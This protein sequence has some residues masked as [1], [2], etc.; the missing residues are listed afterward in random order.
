VAE[1]RSPGRFAEPSR[2]K[3]KPVWIAIASCLLTLGAVF[4]ALNAASGEKKIEHQLQRLYGAEDPQFRRT[5]GVLLGPPIV[6][7]NRVEALLNGDAIFAAML[8]AI[9]Q[10][11]HSITFETYIYWSETIGREFA[12]ALVARSR[13]GVRVHVL[14]DWVGSAKMEQRYLD[15]MKHAGV[16]VERY[17]KPNWAGLFRMN[18]RT[19]RKV[20]VVDGA[21]GFTGG[22]GIADK[23]RGNAQDSEH[24]RDTHFRVEGPVVA[25]MQSVFMDNWIKATGR[26]LH[27]ERYFPALE[28]HGEQ[29]AQMFSSSPTGGS[30]SMHLMYLMALTAATRSIQLSSSYFVPDELAV[31]ALVAAA[32]RG[33]KVQIIT[34]GGEIDSDVVRR[35]SRARWGPLLEA[36]VLIAEYQPTMFHC[37]VL[38][39]DG[40]LVSVGSTNFDNRSFRLNDEANLNVVSAPFA[41]QQIEVFQRDLQQSKPITLQAWQQRPW[42]EKV[43]ERAASW[44]GSQL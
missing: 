31:K 42:Q 12:D 21:V 7:G 34:P 10:A 26:V 25:Q 9:G 3:T 2:M 17:H 4:V 22:V 8:Q 41:R 27:G 29:A 36:G 14:L 13:A 11:R 40:L 5:L 28:S 32:R 18:N 24:W 44:F 38:V 1:R 37:K 43:L 16:E 39:V 23:W 19:H 35:A 20:L 30:E 15:E 33:V 6:E